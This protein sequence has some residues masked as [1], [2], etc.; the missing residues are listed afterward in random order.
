MAGCWLSEHGPEEKSK[1][2]LLGGGDSTSL[3]LFTSV[4]DL[5]VYHYYLLI[6][7]FFSLM[8]VF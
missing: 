7:F 6:F 1:G 3:K 4:W 2:K 8:E 5:L